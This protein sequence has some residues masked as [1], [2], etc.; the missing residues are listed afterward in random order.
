MD[1]RRLEK[2][3]HFLG[4]H[5]YIP[6]EKHSFLCWSYFWL[7]HSVGIGCILNESQMLTVFIFKMKWLPYGLCQYIQ[8]WF[9]MCLKHLLYHSRSVSDTSRDCFLLL[10]VC[11]LFPFPFSNSNP[12]SLIPLIHGSNHQTFPR[13]R[14][15]PLRPTYLSMAIILCS[16]S[17][18][19]LWISTT[20][21]G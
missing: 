1:L 8:Y 2:I 18:P 16:R 15:V 5:K 13:K 3:A 11:L 9:S 14:F 17:G 12:H 10:F 21:K 20:A 6:F 7:K 19:L 4:I